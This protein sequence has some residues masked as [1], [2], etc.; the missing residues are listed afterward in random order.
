MARALILA[1]L[2]IVLAACGGGSDGAPDFPRVVTLG[3]GDLFPRILSHTLAVGPNRFSMALFDAADEEVLGARV[4]LRFYD[5]NGG[6]PA[7]HAETDAEFVP[8]ERSFEDEQAGGEKRVTGMTG[9]YV[10]SVDFDAAGDWGVEVNA[11]TD[12]RRY[13][14]VPF[15]FNVLERS[16][17]PAIGEQAPRSRQAVL[18]DVA[19]ITAIDSSSPPRPHM[20]DTTIA[21]ALSNGRPAVIAFATPAFCE[22]RLC[23]PVMDTVMD[24]LYKRYRGSATF[25]HV[26]PYELAPLRERNVQAPVT[27]TREWR[28]DTEPWIFVVAADGRV[29]AKFE[30]VAGVDEVERALMAV[31]DRPAAAPTPAS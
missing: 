7:F 13:E 1:L 30:G 23:A 24:P 4:R 12:G 2:G 19:D 21:D 10:A 3:E 26:E 9:V 28:I 17:E 5:L 31:L 18:A 20:H 16:P 15:R 22:S 27:A 29:A 25:I 8:M 11:T 6:E 14:P